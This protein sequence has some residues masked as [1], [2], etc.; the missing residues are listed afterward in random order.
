MARRKQAAAEAVALTPETLTP[1]R[2]L[3]SSRRRLPR[4]HDRMRRNEGD[5]RNASGGPIPSRSRPSTSKATRSASGKPDEGRPWQMQ[6]ISGPAPR[7]RC[8][9][10]PS[11]I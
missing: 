4:L 6:S 9:P 10:T 5:H 7:T 2:N 11:V 8:P 3:K 1:P